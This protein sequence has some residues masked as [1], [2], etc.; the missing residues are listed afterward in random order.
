MSNAVKGFTLVELMMVLAIAAILLTI[1]VP[2]FHTFT[3]NSRLTKQVNLLAASIATARG[4]AAKRGAKVVVC[5]S[6][7]P[8]AAKPAC[9]GTAGTW[10][11]GWVVFVDADNDLTVDA[12]TDVVASFRE[13]S[14]VNLITNAGATVA[15]N[16]DG[17]TTAS[18]PATFAICDS[19]GKDHGK[20]LSLATTGRVTTKTDG[21]VNCTP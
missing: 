4:E 18:K 8:V 13:E 16:P 20:E 14:G 5:Q 10:S 9:D 21:A 3:Q 7:D 1:A 12:T 2:S 19:R 11:K 6:D 15:F 17:S